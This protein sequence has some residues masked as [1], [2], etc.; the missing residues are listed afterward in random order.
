MNP[1]WATLPDPVL[2]RKTN[3]TKQEGKGEERGKVGKE[4]RAIRGKRRRGRRD[5]REETDFSWEGQIAVD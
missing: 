4:V 2:K 3:K 5:R 1:K